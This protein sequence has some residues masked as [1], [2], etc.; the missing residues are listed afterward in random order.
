[1]ELGRPDTDQL[2]WMC[3]GV[4]VGL[5]LTMD[6]TGWDS[7]LNTDHGCDWVGQWA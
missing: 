7:G 3:L 5:T 2:P 1:M 4:T 6:V